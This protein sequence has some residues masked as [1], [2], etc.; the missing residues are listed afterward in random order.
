MLEN[1]MIHW[2]RGSD[3]VVVLTM[4]D[5]DQPVNTMNQTYVESMGATV[6]RLEAERDHITGVILTSAKESFFA[7]GDIGFMSEARVENAAE[8]S[9]LCTLLKAQLRRL[10]TLGKPLA[11]AMNG[12]A[13]GGGYEIALAC[14]RRIALD[15]PG[16]RI[17]LPEVTLGLLPGAGGVSRTVRLL[18]LQDALTDV[19]LQGQRYKPGEALARGLVHELATTPED[20][21]AKARR[22]VLAHPESAQPW[23]TKGFRIPGG[24][25]SH[26]KVAASLPAL[27]AHL[28][29]RLRG[30]NVPAPRNIL[31]AAVESAQVDLEAG[32]K[33]ETSYLVELM[34]GQVAKNMMRAFFHDM[35]HIDSGGS[36]PAG[37][38]RHTAR[39]VGV[40]GAGMMGAGIAYSCARGGLEVVLKDISADAARRGRRYSEK[41]LAKA[42][43]RGRMSREKADGI[44]ARITPTADP[45][46]LADCDLVIEAVFEDPALKHQVFGE[47]EDVI[48]PDAVLGSNTSTLPITMLAGGVRRPEDFIGLHFFSPV[49]KMPLLEIITGEKTGDHTVAKAVDIARQIGKTPIVVND[50]RGF[51]TSRVISKFI[52]EA[53]AMLGE[54]LHPASIEQAASQAGYPAPP[55]QLLDELTLTLPRTIRE[56]TKAAVLAGDGQWH[57][58]GS[59]AVVDR[60]IDEFGRGGRSSGAGFYTYQDGRRTGL[61]PGLYQHF[62]VVGREIPF[63]DMKERMLFAEALD[64][65]RCLDE[66]VLRSVPDANVGSILGIGFP[67]WTG[68]VLQYINGYPGGPSGFVVRARELAD[69][70]GERFDPPASLVARAAKG[71]IYE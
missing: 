26:P 64:T 32:Q 15:T 58:H 42:M 27:A 35:R 1:N 20:M 69:R 21:L 7:G 54:G 22:W 23:D 38:A 65:V 70:Y 30:A 52:D 45:A 2:E 31:A 63:E 40:L 16:S 53:V 41:L 51:F 3:G 71:G 47:I 55:L 56:E 18:G 44:L 19:L 24:A 57:P 6:A 46:D 5:P 43:A 17:G 48:A 36:R 33:I 39:K 34:T 66:G 62:T 14:H 9:E 50:S 67:A 13:L 49:D 8:L 68:G 10:E 4:D 61:W 25:P 12:T 59:E 29:K 60:M 28:R 37:Y 11:A